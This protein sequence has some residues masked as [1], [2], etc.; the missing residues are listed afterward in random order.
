MRAVPANLSE[1][2]SYIGADEVADRFGMSLDWVY[3]RAKSGELPSY[4]LPGGR[5]RFRYSEVQEAIERF[6]EGPQIARLR[7]A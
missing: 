1:P 4:K 7:R 3:E 6:R 2:E 5:R